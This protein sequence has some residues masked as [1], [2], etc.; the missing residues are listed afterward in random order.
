M[1]NT[2]ILGGVAEGVASGIQL[3][4]RVRDSRQM[5]RLREEQIRLTEMARQGIEGDITNEGG[6]VD[7]Y[8]N[9]MGDPYGVRLF[10]WMKT[11][12]GAGVAPPAAL[13]GTAAAPTPAAA[14]PQAPG[15]AIPPEGMAGSF[16]EGG[17]PSRL[18]EEEARQRRIERQRAAREAKA[19]QAAP[20]KAGALKSGA[21]GLAAAGAISATPG[22]Y[23][24]ST[25]E[26]RTRMGLSPSRREGIPRL[27]EDV[28]VRT[29]GVLGD[30]GNAVT[31]GMAGDAGRALGGPQAPM[32]AQP[33]PAAA[34][35][36]AQP[37]NR[38]P[39]GP[40][41]SLMASRRSAIPGPAAPPPA[42]AV[43]AAQ[44]GGID[45]A[46]VQAAPDEMPTMNTKD[47]VEYRKNAVVN[48]I[49]RGSTPAEAHAMVDKIQQRGFMSQ[50]QQS[51]AYLQAGNPVAAAR[52]LK[53]AYQYFPNGA[54]VKFG[55]QGNNLIGMGYSED[56]GKPSGKPMVLN[57]E[58]LSI[59]L[60]NFANP[61]AFRAWTK[62]WRD[63]SFRERKYQEVEKPVAS[64]EMGYRRAMGQAALTNA[65][66]DTI[67]ARRSGARDPLTPGDFARSEEV[68]RSELNDMGVLDQMDEGDV[69]MLTAAMSKIRQKEPDRRKLPDNYIVDSVVRAYEDGT[70]DE[71]LGQLGIQ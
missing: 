56:T 38:E 41:A 27:V 52:A 67:R 70:L 3:G 68:F 1:P 42:A 51:L 57:P 28:G 24:T 50:G 36:A 6:T 39:Q 18:K 63:E 37:T 66:A 26:Y 10:N 16:A 34:T 21:A 48:A 2:S 62:D 14:V 58:R 9:T 32:A 20:K 31:G 53:A 47:W 12:F 13:P 71:K 69:R 55:I 54:D 29:A 8:S 19:G 45:W 49:K 15:Y 23:N 46:N 44:Q 40:P 11:K 4:Q 7:P 60:E 61:A 17:M 65:E 64:N 43:S 33:A 5:E 30:V 25:D 22:A 59:M 35:A